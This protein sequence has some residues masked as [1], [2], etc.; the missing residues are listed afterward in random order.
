[1]LNE[2]RREF[3]QQLGEIHPSNFVVLPSI[4]VTPI[5]WS[6]V[7][8]IG[9]IWPTTI[10]VSVLI[11]TALI[12]MRVGAIIMPMAPVSGAIPVVFPRMAIAPSKAVVATAADVISKGE[13]T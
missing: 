6:S 11:S 13:M 12:R 10:I 8:V 3:S 4:V 1:L 5:I 2:P 7:S 9:G